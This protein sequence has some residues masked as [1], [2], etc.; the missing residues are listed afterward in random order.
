[1]TELLEDSLNRMEHGLPPN[2]NAQQE[3][4]RYCQKMKRNQIEEEN[5]NELYLTSGH[6]II[7][8]YPKKYF[9]QSSLL[10]DGYSLR[11]Y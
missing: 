9:L 8:Y 4:Q 5:D 7:N 11:G 10:K 1:M 6:F 3:W 2:E